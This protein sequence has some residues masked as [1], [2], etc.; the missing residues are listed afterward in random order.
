[1]Y[2]ILVFIILAMLAKII[3]ISNN[4][5]MYQ[6]K[7]EETQ[8]ENKKLRAECISMHDDIKVLLERANDLETE[9]NKLSEEIYNI[10]RKGN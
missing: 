5:K 3:N 9:R 10:K 2:I 6:I 4:S 7:I 8:K 1:M